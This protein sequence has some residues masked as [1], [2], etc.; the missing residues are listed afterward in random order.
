MFRKFVLPVLAILGVWAVVWS[1]RRGSTPVVSVQ[2]SVQPAVNPFKQAVSGAGIVEPESENIAVSPAIGG[3]V[4]EVLVKWGDAV[5]NGQPLYQIDPRPL[6]AQIAAQEADVALKEAAL[7]QAEAGLERLKA[8]S[9]DEDKKIAAAHVD[10]ARVLEADAA[11][12]WQRMSKIAK[13]QAVSEDDVNRRHF[14]Y[15]EQQANHQMEQANYEKVMAGSWDK[16]ILVQQA[17]VKAAQ[18]DVS[19]SNAKLQT[20]H[21]DLDRLTVRAPVDGRV[22]RINMRKGE[23]VSAANVSTAS[24]GAVV[25]GDVDH[26]NVR[27]DID[28]ADVPR[29]RETSQAFGFV[30]GTT[31]KQVKLEFV[32]VEPFVVPKRNLTGA[33]TERV[34]TRVL[35][36][37]YRLVRDGNDVPVYVGEQMDVYVDSADAAPAATQTAFGY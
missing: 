29:Y 22:L 3:I 21:V 25:V 34:D 7:A 35:Q 5:K 12:Q 17:A 6:Q 26:L 1:I 18:A 10:V 8:G 13:S 15:L 16:D 14:S 11:D 2:G 31:Q 30:R 19:A 37:I 27:V 36:V 9:R 28:E 33:N 32:R 20:L 4:T 23:Y 24:D